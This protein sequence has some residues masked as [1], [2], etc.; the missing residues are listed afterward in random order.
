[1]F[2]CCKN[3]IAH[4]GGFGGVIRPIGE[5]VVSKRSAAEYIANKGSVHVHVELNY[6]DFSRL[7]IIHV[8]LKNN[9]NMKIPAVS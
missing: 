2:V 3:C 9:G 7:K 4:A 1:M 5:K 6:V 8:T